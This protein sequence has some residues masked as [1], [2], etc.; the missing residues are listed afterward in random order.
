MAIRSETRSLF[1]MGLL[2]NTPLLLAVVGTVLLQLAVIYMP[3]LN[4]FFY[5]Q[6]LTLPELLI[7][8]GVSAVVFVVVEIE[9][10]VK[11]K[12]KSQK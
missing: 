12:L 11:R 2:S 8:F 5:T 10:T 3:G 9:K 1:K 7:A 6:P 4:K